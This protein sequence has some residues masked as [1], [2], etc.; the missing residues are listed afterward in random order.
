MDGVKVV[1][2]KRGFYDS[3]LR[4]KGD[5]F[6]FKGEDL[7]KLSKAP[8]WCEPVKVCDFAEVPEVPEV[9]E[10]P[11]EPETREV[12]SLLGAIYTTDAPKSDG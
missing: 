9:P 3:V 1:A 10:A 7:D 5:E 11:E 8:S 4:E 6:W 2:L 12:L